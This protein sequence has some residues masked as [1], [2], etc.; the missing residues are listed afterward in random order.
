LFDR[1]YILMFYPA[2]MK[3]G[4]QAFSLGL[5]M[6][7][8]S[9]LFFALLVWAHWACGLDQPLQQPLCAFREGDCRSLGY[10]LFGAIACIGAVY[11]VGLRRHGQQ[12]EAAN[13]IGSG[14]LLLLIVATPSEWVL[15]RAAAIVL[16]FSIY[17]HYAIV[18][19]VG[20]RVLLLFHAFFPFL[21]AIMTGL[22]S[23]GLW[24]KGMIC[25]LVVVAVIHHHIVMRRLAIIGN[26]AGDSFQDAH[27]VPL[28]SA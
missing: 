24:Q 5:S 28:E 23:Y 13:A 16:L 12:G 10:A 25:Y 11:A 26:S 18:L 2:S 22:Q 7:L 8:A 9:L 15:H 1:G 20:P 27:A 19:S 4:K 14:L 3:A 6:K 17:V 21:L